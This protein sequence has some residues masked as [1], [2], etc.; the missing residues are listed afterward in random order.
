RPE[1]TPPS[2]DAK[3]EASTKPARPLKE[4]LPTECD[5]ATMKEVDSADTSISERTMTKSR[6]W[7]SLKNSA[8][9]S[10]HHRTCSRESDFAECSLL[11]GRA[12]CRRSLGS[13]MPVKTTDATA[14]DAAPMD[15]KMTMAV[16]STSPTKSSNPPTIRVATPPSV[17]ARPMTTPRLPLEMVCP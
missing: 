4:S 5:K 3:P 10:L 8:Q 11:D 15:N 1:T 6:N 12:A 16:R 7:V 14:H 9:V 2:S 17:V 13:T